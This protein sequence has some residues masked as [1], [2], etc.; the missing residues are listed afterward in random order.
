MSEIISFKEKLSFGIGPFGQ[1][2]IYTLMANFLLFYYTDIFGIT[3]ASAG[4]LLTV[5]RVW[6]AVN[7]PMMG[8]IADRTH[9]RWGKFRPYLL[10]T[11]I[12][13]LPFAVLT[14]TVPSFT[15]YSSKLIWAYITYIGFGMLYTASDVPFWSLSSVITTDSTQ[16]NNLIAYPRF[17]ATIG[18]AIA[19]VT[20]QPLIN[21][22]GQG[23]QAKGF[24]M[25][26][27]IYSLLTIFCF[28]ICFFGVKERVIEPKSK[29]KTLFSD[30]LKALYK[31]K[32]LILVF[33]SG[34]FLGIATTSKLSSLVYLAKYNLYDEGIFT[35]IAGINIPFILLGILLVPP[36]SKRI[37]KIK[38]YVLFNAIFAIGSFLFY[39]TGWSNLTI[40]L[41]FNCISSIGMS[42]P[43]VI[44]TSMIADT[45]EYSQLNIGTRN[46]G[47]IF[48]T[49]IFMAKIT[50][51]LSG[52]LIAAMLT[53]FHYIPN[54]IQTLQTQKGILSM[55]ALIPAIAAALAIVPMHHY[56]LDEKE[57]ARIVEAIKAKQ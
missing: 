11:P 46:E 48:S 32:P 38:T 30:S 43:L 54:E 19:L 9:S 13:F 3:A 8:I 26:A 55:T 41:V 27:L 22:F 2:C 1:N 6:D 25:T 16:R 4:L 34:C 42:A 5:A 29:N 39:F 56:K 57:H 31:N 33:I 44:Q 47:I 15:R 20:T 37:G 7:D 53:A 10:F 17:I 21:R 49:Q 40:L 28:W 12:L 18:T 35:L 50:S 24:Q 45:I 36:I 51:A 23:N 52:L 14:F